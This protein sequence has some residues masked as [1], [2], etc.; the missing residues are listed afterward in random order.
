MRTANCY[1]G[2]RCRHRR[3]VEDDEQQRNR[4]D[5]QKRDRLHPV[6]FL[7]LRKGV[8]TS[9]GQGRRAPPP[10]CRQLRI[11]ATPSKTRW[12]RIPPVESSGRSPV[13]EFCLTR[14]NPLGKSRLPRP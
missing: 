6:H 2:S 3:R 7:P 8:W 9:K 10:S 5:S 12:D 13:F 14:T 1:L 11:P 4:Q